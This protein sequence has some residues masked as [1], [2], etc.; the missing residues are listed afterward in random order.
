MEDGL[1]TQSTAVCAISNSSLV[2]V[3]PPSAY[4]DLRTLVK[5]G[6]NWMGLKSL[7][8]I[9]KPPLISANQKMGS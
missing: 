1:P 9:K 7:P 6:H 5:C 4:G 3:S 8:T 2:L